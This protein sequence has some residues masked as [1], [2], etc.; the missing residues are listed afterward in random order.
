MYIHVRRLVRS[1]STCRPFYLLPSTFYPGTTCTCTTFV[2]LSMTNSFI[3][4]TWHLRSLTVI[5]FFK[6][7]LLSRYSA[8]VK[9]IEIVSYIPTKVF[10]SLQLHTIHVLHNFFSRR[11]ICSNLSYPPQHYNTIQTLK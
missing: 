4:G 3:E 5:F 11:Q 7:Q 8:C 9:S 10:Q 6:A 1:T 2:F